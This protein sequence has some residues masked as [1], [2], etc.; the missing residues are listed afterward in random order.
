MSSPR[1][2]TPDQGCYPICWLPANI[3][4]FEGY[5]RFSTGHWLATISRSNSHVDL[6]GHQKAKS[7]LAVRCQPA[8]CPPT[9]ERAELLS[10]RFRIQFR[11]LQGVSLRESR[12]V[13][14]CC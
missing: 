3:P 9:L 2:D 6:S 7:I 5:S 8:K 10:F 12:C 1:A 4:Q 11:I 13:A 14:K